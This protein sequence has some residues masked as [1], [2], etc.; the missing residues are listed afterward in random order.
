MTINWRWFAAYD[1]EPNEYQLASAATR[2][3]VIAQALPL[4]EQGETFHIVE[5]VLSRAAKYQDCDVIPF[6]RQRNHE[7]LTAGVRAVK[8]SGDG[9]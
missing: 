2:D 8:L 6:I 3:D 7:T 4:L 5:A 1:D 9:Q